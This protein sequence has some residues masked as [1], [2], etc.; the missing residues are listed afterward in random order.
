[1]VELIDVSPANPASIASA[2][3]NASRYELGRLQNDSSLGYCFWLLTR[4]TWLARNQNFINQL[5]ELDLKITDKSTA[6]GFIS[7]VSDNA[8][9]KCATLPGSSVFREMANLALK[10]SLSKTILTS[11]PS[12]FGS[13]LSSIQEACREYSTKDNFGNLSRI[14]FSS[15]LTRFLN[16][17][18]D[19]E[20]SNH[21]GPAFSL[22]NIE[23]VNGFTNALSTY[24][25]QVSKIMEDFASG[26]YAKKNWETQ[27]L[28]TEVD[29]QKFV[30]IALR[31]LQMEIGS[32][33][34]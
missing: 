5:K 28:I 12:L 8:R 17:F 15:F 2:T 10:E 11:T 7:A 23:D 20:I 19:K 32:E 34:K 31:K 22:E 16:Y 26:W 1:L 18:I 29:A 24:S 6:F 33:G 14:Y 3:L 4:I 25:W 30:A 13:S 9:Q 27:G 21:I